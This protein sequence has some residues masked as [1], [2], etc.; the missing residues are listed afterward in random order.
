MAKPNS[1]TKTKST[2]V[3]SKVEKKIESKKTPLQKKEFKF[4]S[5]NLA[6][7]ATPIIF[8]LFIMWFAFFVRSGPISLSGMDDRVEQNTY[9]Q[10]QNLISQDISNKYKYLTDI[11]KQELTLKE[12]KEVQESGIYNFQGQDINIVDLISQNQKQIKD[13][14]KDEKGQTYLNAIDPYHF[15]MFADNYYKNGHTGDKL[16]NGTPFVSNK[17]APTGYNGT[18]NPQFH[19]WLESKLFELNDIDENSTLGDKTAAIYLIGVVFAMF[20]GLVIFLLIRIYTNDLFALFGALLLVS[21]GTFVSRTVAGFVDTDA[22]NVFFPILISLFTVLAFNNKNRILK[23]LY[24]TIA[25]FFVG[26]FLW[27]WVYGWFIFT[28]ICLALLS[29]LGYLILINII[30]KIKIKE[31]IKEI[32]NDLTILFTFVIS[33]VIFNF[34]FNGTNILSLT[35]KSIFIAT[36]NLASISSSIW[37]NVLSSVAELNAASFNQIVSSVGGKVIFII[38]MIG[39][40]FLALD[41]ITK[42]KELAIYKKLISIFAV[43]WYLLI[44]SGG[45]F[46]SFTA[47]LP[48]FFLIL[49]F[50]PIG[51]AIILSIFNHNISNKVFSL[52]LLSIWIAGT[53][54]MSLNGIRFILLLV[55]AFVISFALGMF[56]LSQIINN[57]LIEEFKIKNNIKQLVGGFISITILFLVLFNPIA[58][59]AIAISQNTAPN[60]DDAWY[61][62][63]EKIKDNS[64]EDAIITSWWDFGH[65][66]STVSQR[67]S[68]FDGAS[69]TIPQAHWV[70]RYLMENDDLVAKDILKMIVCS[71]NGAFDNFFNIVGKDSSDAVKINKIIYSTFGKSK[72]ETKLLLENNKYYTLNENQ[73][74]LILNKLKCDSPSEDFV[75]ASGDMVGKAGVWAHWGS[76]DFT[77][78]YVKDNYKSLTSSEIA[79]KIDENVTLIEQYVDELKAIGIKANLENIKEDDLINRWFADY[80]SYIPI[81]GQYSF[82][83]QDNNSTLICQNGITINMVTGEVTSQ[84]G[85]DVKFNYLYYPSNN[86]KLIKMDIG[87]GDIDLLLIPSQSGFNI[88]MM[89]SPLGASQFTK[90]FYLNGFGQDYL[91][92]FDQRQ[93]VTGIEIKIFKVKWNSSNDSLNSQSFELNN[94]TK[95][96]VEDII[97]ENLNSSN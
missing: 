85:P 79:T 91:E 71:G 94:V 35:Y 24:S 51:F 5:I 7:I 67:G 78:K 42:K 49:L 39:L 56:Y 73:V 64:Q 34:I 55:P 41:F 43:I 88:M 15:L 75:I 80:P 19:I 59:Q 93:S 32:S 26:M 66:F 72:N 96:E 36:N 8:I 21:I 69:Q 57:F 50:L 89:Q 1:K 84:F 90:M 45:L 61:A 48:I 18:Y 83:C 38:A 77:K 53:I 12:F 60:F 97:G 13:A 58:T 10:I 11:E 4:N 87:T 9:V 81:Q 33:S 16:I 76:W 74:N 40:T 63:M 86:N 3:K 17:I 29:Y 20:S 28:F 68:T 14:F 37:P 95:E 25:G 22:Y 65:F 44:I 6:K 82:E 2:S 52:I 54:Y 27:A 30:Q 46:I 23:I 31:F 62:S 70:G 92:V 47:N